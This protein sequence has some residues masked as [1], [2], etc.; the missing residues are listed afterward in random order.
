MWSV[1]AAGLATTTPEQKP[2]CSARSFAVL[3]GGTEVTR[4][5]RLNEGEVVCAT[6]E[7]TRPLCYLVTP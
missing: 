7:T 4:A 6:G 3:A 2:S 5:R 1:A